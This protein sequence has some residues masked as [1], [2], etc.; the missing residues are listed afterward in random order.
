MFDKLRKVQSSTK[1]V[2][3][4]GKQKGRTKSKKVLGT[5]LIISVGI[6]KKN[7]FKQQLLKFLNPR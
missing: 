2:K 5:F 6:G 7:N 3:N 1:V 4:L